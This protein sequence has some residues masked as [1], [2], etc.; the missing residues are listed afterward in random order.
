MSFSKGL[1]YYRELRGFTQERLGSKLNLKRNTISNYEKGISEPGID[2]LL[3]I[4]EVLDVSLDE[5]LG[6]KKIQSDSSKENLEKMAPNVAPNVA[7]NP[8]QQNESIQNVAESELEYKN[9]RIKELEK[10]V[11]KLQAQNEAYLNAFKAIGG[12]QQEEHR[13]VG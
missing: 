13:E 4:V 10:E 8:Y 12:S 7:P 9:E 1:K 6:L 11:L 2:M 3:K 5:L